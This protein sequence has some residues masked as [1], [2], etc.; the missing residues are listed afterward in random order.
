MRE[1]AGSTSVHSA[2]RGRRLSLAA[3]A[4]VLLALGGAW[5]ARRGSPH[6]A[7]ATAE[8]VA[9]PVPPP[10]PGELAMPDLAGVRAENSPSERVVAPFP[11]APPAAVPSF[12]GAVLDLD[13]APIAGARLA[14]H[15]R[16]TL[17]LPPPLAVG[18]TD[19]GG[20]FALASA[21]ALP[22]ATLVAEADGF[23]PVTT[24]VAAGK[25]CVIVLPWS[26]EVFGVVRDAT[27][28]APLAGV[29]L[30]CEREPAFA[31]ELDGSYRVGGFPSGMVR[32]LRARRAG[33]A[34]LEHEVLLRGK[35]AQRLDLA[36]VPGIPIEVEVFDRD[37]GSPL[38]GAAVSDAWRAD[39]WTHS[40]ARGRFT[41][42][43]AVEQPSSLEITLEGYWPMTWSWTPLS[44]SGVAVSRLPMAQQIWIRGRITD[45]EGA[46]LPQS[47][48]DAAYAGGVQLEV[49]REDL[50]A[51]GTPGRLRYRASPIDRAT[52]QIVEDGAYRLAILGSD[53]PFTLKA[54][55]EG[56]VGSERGPLVMP[57]G[58]PDTVVDFVLQG[59]ACVRGR[60]QQDGEPWTGRLLSRASDGSTRF[61]SWVHGEYAIRDLPAGVWTL[62]LQDEGRVVV[63]SA[64]L[65]VEA[66]Q[67]YEQD[68]VWGDEA[69]SGTITGRV[70]GFA[71]AP[72]HDVFVRARPVGESSGRGDWARVEPDG[73]FA[74]RVRA[75]RTYGVQATRRTTWT[76]TAGPEVVAT[77]D[78]SGIELTLPGLGLVRLCLIDA[79][80]RS[81]FRPR[82][83]FLANALHWR[84]LSGEDGQHSDL[85]IDTR[86]CVE[87]ELPVGEVE[88][89][90]DL[91]SEGYL[92]LPRQRLSV[93]GGSEP[94]TLTIEVERGVAARLRLV[95]A[96][97]VDPA[98]RNGR[99]LF[100]VE[101][102]QLGSI[103]GP[104]DN[105]EQGNIRFGN[106][107]LRMR[108]DD[109]SLLHQKLAEQAFSEAGATL[110]GLRPGHYF[111]KSYPDDLAFEPAELDLAGPERIERTIVWRPRAR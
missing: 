52:S 6:P 95:S 33:Y 5:L 13:G 27:S 96:A 51:L 92:P 57:P 107:S 109:R 56:R 54:G 91:A 73:A 99:L 26:C 48:V 62:L 23:F 4:L 60:A 29:L 111:V 79:A 86:G 40:D 25:E 2:A 21:S 37:T 63:A 76:T 104:Y 71:P 58:A 50:D 106:D 43:V 32:N 108:I 88:W 30:A 24:N 61:G 22:G 67:E 3:L 16:N 103:S 66:G 100:L 36:L 59:A 77:P 28:G 101:R 19:A 9:A 69:P 85:Q 8:H 98:A 90:L 14:L 110:E 41:T 10:S 102:S 70:L 12:L 42:W 64:T 94:T 20:R 74:L 68:F 78:A 75:G 18:T 49:A 38:A 89:E 7:D 93:T 97:G 17:P 15:A 11:E 82:S 46:A 55:A 35:E 81:P 83:S 47:W 34:V 45:E 39:G 84:S 65:A 87:L 44:D 72:G 105:A 1:G 80:T 53:L 31:S